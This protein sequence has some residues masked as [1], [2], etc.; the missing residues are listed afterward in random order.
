MPLVLTHHRSVIP[1]PRLVEK[2]Q[3]VFAGEIVS[4]VEQHELTVTLEQLEIVA[5]V[6]E[7]VEMPAVTLC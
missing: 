5:T 4:V 7:I 6:N 3:V 2:V 1:L